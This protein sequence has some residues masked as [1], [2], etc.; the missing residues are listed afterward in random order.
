MAKKTGSRAKG[1]KKTGAAKRTAAKPKAAAKPNAAAK[2]KPR[3]AARPEPR[4][5]ARPEPRAAAKPEPKAATKGVT[6]KRKKAA[7]EAGGGRWIGAMSVDRPDLTAALM[8]GGELSRFRGGKAKGV[9]TT[10]YHDFRIDLWQLP[11]GFAFVEAYLEGEL[12]DDKSL[13]DAMGNRLATLSAHATKRLGTFPVRS[14]CVGLIDSSMPGTHVT[15]AHVR[16]AA[17]ADK[18]TNVDLVDFDGTLALIPVPN[19]I[20]E[21]TREELSPEGVFEDDAL[22]ELHARLRVR[23]IGDLTTS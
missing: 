20:Y 3:A 9:V 11:D 14:G 13:R 16:K 15:A 22:G 23:R 6:A 8:D 4:A 18:V 10:H 12:A 21:L 7:G 17:A 1:G 2:P 19:G 5:A